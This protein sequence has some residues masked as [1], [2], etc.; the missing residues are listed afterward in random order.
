MAKKMSVAEKITKQEKNVFTVYAEFKRGETTEKKVDAALTKLHKLYE[1]RQVENFNREVAE[2][3]EALAIDPST[4]ATL[5]LQERITTVEHQALDLHTALA[6]GKRLNYADWQLEAIEQNLNVRLD[7]L[8][9]ELYIERRLLEP[10][11]CTV[12]TS[13]IKFVGPEKLPSRSK[14]TKVA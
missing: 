14:K 5:S 3:N 11:V 10:K 6:D 7:L 8:N 9:N 2:F 13:D 4:M 1:E 12:G